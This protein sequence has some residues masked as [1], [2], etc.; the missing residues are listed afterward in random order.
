MIH[1]NDWRLIFPKHWPRLRPGEGGRAARVLIAA[2]IADTGRLDMPCRS[3]VGVAV[4]KVLREF[5]RNE[6]LH[7]T[8]R[9]SI[10]EWGR[11]VA[12]D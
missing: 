12:L 8:G 1:L 2:L 11:L 6:G 7:P 9:V 3:V 4:V 5:Q 10:M